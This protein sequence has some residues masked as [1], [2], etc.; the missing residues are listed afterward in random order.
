[1]EKRQKYSDIDVSFSRDDQW[2][3]F[4]GNRVKEICRLSDPGDWRYVPS[5]CNPADL[6]SRGCSLSRLIQSR[7]WEGPSWLKLSEEFWP[8]RYKDLN[9]EEICAERKKIAV[10]TT[11]KS[12]YHWYMKYFS[13]FIKN[14]RMMAWIRRYINNLRSSTKVKGELSVK[15]IDE[16]ELALLELVQA[17]IEVDAVPVLLDDIVVFSKTFGEHLRRLKIILQCLSNVELNLN[18][19]KCIFGTKRIRVFG[20]LVDGNGIYLDPEKIEAIAKV[21]TPRSITEMRS[22]IG[23]CSYFRRFIE[24]LA[25]KAAPLHEILKKDKKFSWDLE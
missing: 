23:I 4:V 7:W 6:P 24:H 12:T 1:M 25:K 8:S 11:V 21:P 18:S 5:E 10:V 22:F 14:V 13:S 16:A 17:E 19:K 3:T 9:E 2:G 15:E 20:H